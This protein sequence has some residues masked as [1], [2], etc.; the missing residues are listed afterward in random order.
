M[1]EGVQ[2]RF[3]EQMPLDAQ[4]GWRRAEMVTAAEI[5][6]RLGEQVELVEDAEDALSRGSAP[7]ELFRV[8]GTDY[9]VG[10]IASVS[11]AVLRGL[12]PGPADRRRAD[13]QLPVRPHR[14]G[15][16]DAAARRR[17]RRRD[18]LALGARGAPASKPGTASTTR[19]S[20][21][22]TGRCRPSAVRPSAYERPST[23]RRNP[24]A[25]RKALSE[26][27]CSAQASQCLRRS[28]GWILGLFHPR[29][30][31]AGR[32]QPLAEQ[33]SCVRQPCW[34]RSLPRGV[35]L[36]VGD[37]PVIT[38]ACSAGGQL[39]PVDR[40]GTEPRR[41][42]ALVGLVGHDHGDVGQHH[43]AGEEH[44][45][46]RAVDEDHRDEAGGS[47]RHGDG[48]PADPGDISTLAGRPGVGDQRGRAL[49]RPGSDRALTV[50]HRV[51]V[52]LLARAPETSVA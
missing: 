4:H 48:V 14:V 27:R 51:S 10:I 35:P 42:G 24:R 7:A 12:R 47:E 36:A 13:P 18:R 3:I 38:S 23:S 1:A 8:A 31:V 16:A 15:S 39:R 45:A 11:Q 25:D 52:R 34:S 49:R 40:L 32:R 44:P 17:E 9:T 20:C 6:D 33:S 26:S 43:R 37:R 30:Y 29:S 19:A 2:L 28:G 50:A 46:Q 5:R 41:S 21:S 22:P